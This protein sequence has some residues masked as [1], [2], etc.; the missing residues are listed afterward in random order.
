MPAVSPTP[1][2]EEPD[3]VLPLQPDAAHIAVVAVDQFALE[4]KEFALRDVMPE[5]LEVPIVLEDDL[6]PL[7]EQ[8][9]IVSHTQSSSGVVA[10]R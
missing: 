1:L 3:D 2:E 9:T 5:G 4:F 7:P 8:Q 10:P 6:F